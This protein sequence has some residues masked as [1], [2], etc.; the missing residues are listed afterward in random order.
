[1][2]HNIRGTEGAASFLEVIVLSMFR[3]TMTSL[4]ETCRH[5]H[6]YRR[7]MKLLCSLTRV[8][9]NRVSQLPGSTSL[10]V[11]KIRDFAESKGT[12]A[13]MT[14]MHRENF[15]QIE[16]LYDWLSHCTSA[17]DLFRIVTWDQSP[18]PC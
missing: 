18:D 16:E 1:M 6:L 14:H 5:A 8:C 13:L 4:G 10:R 11:A 7:Q 17:D 9:C 3:P 15:G 2:G 12:L